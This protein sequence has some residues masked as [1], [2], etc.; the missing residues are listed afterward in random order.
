MPELRKDPIVGRWVIIATERAR[1]P[2]NLVSA[3]ENIFKEEAPCPFCERHESLTPPEIYAV[4]NNSRPNEPNWKVRVVPSIKPML[5]IEG[6]TSRRGAGIYDSMDD[7]GAH[8]VI[9]E[10]P[11]HIANMADLP[12][13]QIRLV[14][15]TYTT[16]INDLEKD[17]RFKSVMAYKNYGWPAGGGK[18]RH[19]RSQIVA[20][21]INPMRVKEELVGARQYFDFHERCVYCDLIRQESQAGDR[22]IVD[23]DNFIAVAPFASRFPFEIWVLPKKHHCDFSKGVT[24]LAYDL[25]RILKEVLLKLKVGLGDPAY[26]FVIHSAPFRR[27]ST[28]ENQWKTINEDYHWHIEIMPR[29]T[30][31]A[32]FEKGTGFY[33]C[34]MPPEATAEFL[35]KVVV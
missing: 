3:S 23:D 32:G 30:H 26:N 17:P 2:G 27:L 31:V 19:S 12:L 1:R 5:R 13:D 15:E 29:L 14:I 21:P 35:R 24:G 16:R 33:I 4:R 28:K 25:A 7:V 11:E 8:E 18:I 34:S 6:A 20:M 9:I 10:T 22:V